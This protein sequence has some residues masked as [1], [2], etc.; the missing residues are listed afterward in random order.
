M[1][2]MKI[3]GIKIDNFSKEEV[4]EKIKEILRGHKQS[5]LVLPYSEFI[6][7]AHQNEEFKQLINNAD[8]S[9]CDGKGLFFAMRFLG[10]PLK[11]RIAGVDLIESISQEFKNI[12]LFGGRPEIVSKVNDKF[13]D[14]V[15]GFLDGYQ[16]DQ[17]VIKKINQVKP[18][19]LIVALGSPK[20][21]EWINQ[22]LNK[23]PSV[24]LALGVG[25]AFDFIS[26]QIKRAPLPLRE[27]GLEWL[28]R[29]TLQPQRAKRV[30][31]AV[32][33]FPYLILKSWLSTRK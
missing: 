31:N 8:L 19:I 16:E 3:L 27:S 18:G 33:V 1:F 10:K 5:Y 21:E 4:L 2:R 26:G 17:V 23:M 6:V 12:F 14:S 15:V 7:R 24:K 29:L 9:L 22:N 30:F 11:E 32:I 13:K 28:W 20:Q 25:G